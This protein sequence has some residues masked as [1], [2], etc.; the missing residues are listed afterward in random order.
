MHGL[1]LEEAKFALPTLGEEKFVPG[2]VPPTCSVVTLAEEEVVPPTCSVH[3]VK[4]NVPSEHDVL[5]PPASVFQPDAQDTEQSDSS[6][7]SKW[8]AAQET[9]HALD[10]SLFEAVGAQDV[11]LYIAVLGGSA[12]QVCSGEQPPKVNA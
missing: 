10:G 6:I 7:I 9:V 4:V 1:A 2:F 12:V 8:P 3:P 11:V 5:T